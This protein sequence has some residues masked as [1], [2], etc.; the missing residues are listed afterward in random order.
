LAYVP[1]GYD[2]QVS[3]GLLI[4]LHAAGGDKEEELL[5]RWKAVC[6]RHDLILVA[7][8]A[9]NPNQWGPRDRDFIAKLLEDVQATYKIDRG[10][11]VAH[12]YQSGGAMAYIVAFANRDLV[13]AVAAVDA[14]LVTS[15]PENEPI[16]RLAF[17]TTTS[18]KGRT[19]AKAI[20]AAVERLRE[21]KYPVTV[22]DLGDEGRY[23]N[24]EELAE[25]VRWIDS[26]D[27]I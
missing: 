19:P 12:G 13:R 2:P 22:R 26:L 27:R 8:R 20:A 4:S 15:P 24:D 14:P 16:H 23:L 18:A 10:R 3:Y 7:P 21:M 5:A 6:D 1:E 17:Y 25:L 11:V 9:Q